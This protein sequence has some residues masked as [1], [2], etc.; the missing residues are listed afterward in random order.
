MSDWA[1]REHGKLKKAGDKRKEWEKLAEET[2]HG[3]ERAENNLRWG[4]N[5]ARD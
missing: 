3:N 1:R 5:H 2:R 4:P